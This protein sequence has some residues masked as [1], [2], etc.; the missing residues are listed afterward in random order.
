MTEPTDGRTRPFADVLSDLDRG[1]VHTEL[2]EQLQALIARVVETG[3]PGSLT[4]QIG[5]KPMPKTDGQVIVSNKIAVKRPESD[6]R[7]AI[8]FVDDEN[9]LTR[10]DPRQ[11]ALPLRGITTEPTEYKEAR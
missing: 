5:V 8:F 11:Q 10:D 4:L 3:K 7:D 9:N 6:R 1:H 2:S